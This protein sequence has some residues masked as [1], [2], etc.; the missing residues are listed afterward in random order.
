MTG[1]HFAQ[2]NSIIWH[3]WST[4]APLITWITEPVEF[5]CFPNFCLVPFLTEKKKKALY[6]RKG[7]NITCPC[8][9]FSATISRY[10]KIR[11]YTSF[12]I[13]NGRSIESLL[14]VGQY[15]SRYI[16]LHGS[17]DRGSTSSGSWF[18]T[19]PWKPSDSWLLSRWVGHR[20]TA[21][22]WQRPMRTPR[23]TLSSISSRLSNTRK[24]LLHLFFQ[25][26]KKNKKQKSV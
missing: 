26:K 10:L 19:P 22:K 17:Q 7:N 4:D 15:S 9:L 12:Y 8:L 2:C 13:R 24:W 25:R 20:L 21:A 1:D 16:L 3:G 5:S 11:L 14:V 6:T 23:A 18:E